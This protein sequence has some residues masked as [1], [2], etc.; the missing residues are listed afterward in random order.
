MEFAVTFSNPSAIIDEEEYKTK[1]SWIMDF[2]NQSRRPMNAYEVDNMSVLPENTNIDVNQH[3]KVTLFKSF[4]LYLPEKESTEEATEPERDTK[5]E[6]KESTEEETKESTEPEE[7]TEESTEPEEETK[8]STE[9]EEE[10]EEATEPEEE[11]KE[12]TEPEEETKESTEP[13]EETKES[14]EPEEE[15]PDEVT[16]PSATEVSTDID[17][18]ILTIRLVYDDLKNK[19]KKVENVRT[20]LKETLEETDIELDSAF[21]AFDKKLTKIDED[22]NA[23]KNKI[24]QIFD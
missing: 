23:L 10:T 4:E 5:E 8:E 13:E 17:N 11:T 6:T 1:R 16:E 12:S 19:K 24:L 14:T 15:E 20:M 3:D 2:S 21:A 7:E 18:T 22:M 9:S